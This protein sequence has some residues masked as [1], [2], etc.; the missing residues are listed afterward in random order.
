MFIKR[1]KDDEEFDTLSMKRLRELVA[2][3]EVKRDK[4]AFDNLFKPR[5]DQNNEENDK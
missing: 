3:Y 5:Q 1:Q 2:K 4:S